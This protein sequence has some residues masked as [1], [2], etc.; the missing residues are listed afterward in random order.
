MRP[1]PCYS[2]LPS[3]LGLRGGGLFAAPVFHCPCVSSCGTRSKVRGEGLDE[4]GVFEEL[5]KDL[6]N[7][8][9]LGDGLDHEHSLLPQVT[10]HH[11]DLYPLR[12]RE[13]ERRIPVKLSTVQ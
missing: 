8:L 1:S 12:E 6:V 7:K 3:P 9:V 10:Q 2:H 4:A 13:R 11:R 5:D